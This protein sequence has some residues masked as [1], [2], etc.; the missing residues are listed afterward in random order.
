MSSSLPKSKQ[1]KRI[2]E[3][4]TKPYVNVE[5]L[6]RKERPKKSQLNLASVLG[7]AIPSET[8]SSSPYATADEPLPLQ[9][10]AEDQPLTEEDPVDASLQSRYYKHKQKL[11]DDWST[12]RNELFEAFIRSEVPVSKC[13]ICGDSADIVVVCAKCS[14]V[15]V[16]CLSC[17][18]FSHETRPLHHRRVWDVCSTSLFFDL[19]A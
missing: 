3:I 12:Q 14:P 17:A 15:Y 19:S 2:R 6:R 10:P 9:N 18:R 13:V 5:V 1:R 16:E 7:E 4:V 11:V 8:S